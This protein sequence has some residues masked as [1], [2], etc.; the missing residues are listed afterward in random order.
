MEG[1]GSGTPGGDRAA[2]YIAEVLAP[3]AIAWGG[4][5][6]A[7]AS[8]LLGGSG[9]SLDALAK[10]APGA[11]G[12]RAAA[13]GVQVRLRVDLA[14]EER[15]AANVIGVVP[16]VDPTLAGEAVVIGAHYDHLRREG[17]AV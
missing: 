2:R 1:R 3:V 15:R 12:P 8:G 17:D 16:G 13:T 7:A 11:S 10:P 4:I 5:P 9:R 14:T 6:R